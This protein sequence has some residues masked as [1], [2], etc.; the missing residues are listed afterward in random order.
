[1]V[2]GPCVRR[3]RRAV[4][5]VALVVCTPL[6]GHKAR[7]MSF[8]CMPSTR[9]SLAPPNERISSSHC[10]TYTSSCTLGDSVEFMP[11]VS[12]RNRSGE[13]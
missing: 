2:T 1:M 8:T 12:M 5:T 10:S 11:R 6:V 3:L 9:K 7:R 13:N 4:S